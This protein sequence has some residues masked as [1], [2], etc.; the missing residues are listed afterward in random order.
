MSRRDRNRIE[1]SRNHRYWTLDY[2]TVLGSRESGAHH[3]TADH[4]I[5]RLE[6]FEDIEG[7]GG[8]L[9]EKVPLIAY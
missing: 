2:R 6:H 9:E 7:L 3:L 4:Q 1:D 5:Q 8:I